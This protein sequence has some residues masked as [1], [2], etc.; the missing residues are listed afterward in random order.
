[1]SVGR[2]LLESA[3]R[4]HIG[5]WVAQVVA[6]ALPENAPEALIAQ[7]IERASVAAYH[8]L[9]QHIDAAAA[10]LEAEGEL[11]E[12][13]AA[14]ALLLHMNKTLRHTTAAVH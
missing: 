9:L 10:Q 6:R 14:R 7:L 3:A 4:R 2:E 12:E 8:A 5:R 13:E 11:S 1:M